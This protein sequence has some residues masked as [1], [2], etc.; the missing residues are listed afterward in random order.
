MSDTDLVMLLTQAQLLLGQKTHHMPL[1]RTNA[2][3]IALSLDQQDAK[4]MAQAANDI[5]VQFARPLSEV[6]EIM[7][8]YICRLH[9]QARIKQYV[10]ILAIKQVKELL[11]T[12]HR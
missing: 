11:R 2:P 5:A 10:S 1:P 3:V 4:R 8:T 7:K 6:Q 9:Q 12:T